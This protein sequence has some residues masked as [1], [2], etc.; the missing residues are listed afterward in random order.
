MK[1]RRKKDKNDQTG[2]KEPPQSRGFQ[3]GEGPIWN[4]EKMKRERERAR[5]A[6]RKSDE[7][8]H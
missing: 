8:P 7:M 3:S 5:S 4:K 2:E 6:E 1:K